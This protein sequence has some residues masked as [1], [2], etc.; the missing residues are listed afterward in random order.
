M[1]TVRMSST[2]VNNMVSNGTSSPLGRIVSSNTSL[3][4]GPSL[5]SGGTN[6]ATLLIVYKGTVADFATFTDRSTRSSDALVSFS[7]TA[8]TGSFQSVGLTS[9][10]MRYVLGRAVTPATASS[11]GLA[12]WF[13]LCRGGTSSLTD[14]G[15]MI[16]TVG[17]AG[18]GADLE[19]PDPNIVSGQ[20]Y[21]SGGIYIN[22]P[23]S[24]TF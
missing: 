3:I 16:G 9:G 21:S 4:S 17:Q 22:F 6:G 24:W 8:G 12:T 5:L 23:L 18:S 19:L 2:L 1:P 7:L 15:A 10:A 20:P 14:K 13:L 11:S